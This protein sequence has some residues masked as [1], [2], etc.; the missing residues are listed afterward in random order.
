MVDFD[1]KRTPNDKMT[2]LIQEN[3]ICIRTIFGLQQ[4]GTIGELQDNLL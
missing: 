1:L 3:K 2:L 4:L